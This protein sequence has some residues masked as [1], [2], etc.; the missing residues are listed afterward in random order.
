MGY[1]PIEDYG[2]VGNMRTVALA[3]KNG[4]IDWLCFP[5][6]DSPSVFAA[7]LDDRK[8]GYFRISPAANDVTLKQHYW[9]DTNVLVTRFFSD[10]GVGEIVDYMPIATLRQHGGFHGLIRRVNVVRGALKF[11]AECRPAFNYARDAHEIEL[12][13]GGAK[14]RS[15]K[16]RLALASDQRL[17]VCGE[18]AVCDFELKEGQSA[19]FELH[20]IDD[21]SAPIALS[22]ERS[23]EL[24]EQTVEYWR[25][26]LHQCTYKGRWREMVYRSALVLKLLTYQPTGAIVAA[27]TC[28]LPEHIGGPRN[29]DYRYTWIR[30]AAF[31]LYSLMRIGFFE[32]ASAFMGWLDQRCR[33]I[34]P[35]DSLQI[36]YGIDGR[37]VLKETTLDHLDGYKGSRPV[38][39]GND[40]YK[41]LQLDIYGELMDSVYLFNKHARPISWELWTWLRRLTN[42]VCDNWQRKDEAIWEVRGGARRFVYSKLMCWVA[43][44]RAIRLARDRS[45]PADWLRWSGVRDEIYMTLQEKGWSEKRKAYVESFGSDAL[46][47][48]SLMMPLVFFVAPDDPRML[49]T[50]DAINRP[51]HE[52]GLVT[53]GLVYRYDTSLTPDG[54][55]GAEGTFN[56]CTFWLVEALTR[57]G[58]LNEAR[59]TLEQMMGFA[60]H[61]GLFS[62]QLGPRGEALGNYPQALTHLSLISAAVNLDKDLG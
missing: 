51:R 31:T 7:I 27:P 36:M 54:L 21:E 11:H 56:T 19:S 24:F 47:A 40:A 57:A 44:D 14:F 48:A 29:W 33:E 2:A 15:P 30:D 25:A 60:N 4:S 43:V 20:A 41:Q 22:D 6:F 39:L 35:D 8:G 58:R 45:F 50:I 13:K 59:L 61:L 49:A 23:R 38:R 42:W 55:E 26:W 52:G 18:A 5:E 17:K 34:E 1:L 28:G 3:G 46:D 12:V 53:S 16:L 37:H 10:D 32:E 62:E 9:P